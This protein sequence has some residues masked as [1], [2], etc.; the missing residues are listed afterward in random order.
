MNQMRTS[1][2]GKAQ[3][4]LHAVTEFSVDTQHISFGILKAMPDDWCTLTMYVI[5][6][7]LPES[8]IACSVKVRLYDWSIRHR[9]TYPD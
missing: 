1:A 8:T 9:Y 3:V 7:R 2:T 4:R 6:Q 5:W